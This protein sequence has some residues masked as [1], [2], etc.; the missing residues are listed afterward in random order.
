MPDDARLAREAVRRLA[1]RKRSGRPRR[2]D[3]DGVH[4]AFRDIFHSAT[5]VGVTKLITTTSQ[6]SRTRI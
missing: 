2:I 6:P 3:R 1:S 4:K 5:T